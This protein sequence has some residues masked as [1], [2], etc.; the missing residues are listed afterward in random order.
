MYKPE[1]VI[2]ELVDEA[3]EKWNWDPAKC[4]IYSMLEPDDGIHERAYRQHCTDR[5]FGIEIAKN[6]KLGDLALCFDYLLELSDTVERSWISDDAGKLVKVYLAVD[7]RHYKTLYCTSDTTLQVSSRPILS[8][9]L[10]PLL[11]P[12]LLC[13]ML[14]D[15]GTLTR[16]RG[17]C[18]LTWQPSRVSE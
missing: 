8:Y 1:R 16:K 9:P 4:K 15:S 7:P 2:S 11:I 10:T 12:R 13:K 14:V 18:F 6:S 17:T 5:W 3:C